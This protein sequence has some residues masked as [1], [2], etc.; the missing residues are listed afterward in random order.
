[1]THE[2]HPVHRSL[3]HFVFSKS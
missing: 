1:M 2:E 3:W